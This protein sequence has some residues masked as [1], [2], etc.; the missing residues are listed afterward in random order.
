M[1]SL[2]KRFSLGHQ[3]DAGYR[4]DILAIREAI[5]GEVFL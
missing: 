5:G 1:P 2:F 4:G 3:G